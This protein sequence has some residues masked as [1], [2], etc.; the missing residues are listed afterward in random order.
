MK[1]KLKQYLLN[2]TFYSDIGERFPKLLECLG[3][4]AKQYFD[5][6]CVVDSYDPYLGSVELSHHENITYWKVHEK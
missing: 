4:E 3:L 6:I 2:R 5:T 1:Q